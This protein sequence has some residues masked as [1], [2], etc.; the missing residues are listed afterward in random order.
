MVTTTS[1]TRD[2]VSCRHLLDILRPHASFAQGLVVTTLPRGGL[3]I[4]QPLNVSESVL[5]AFSEGLHTEDRL[6]WQAVMTARPVRLSELPAERNGYVDQVLAPLGVKHALALPLSGPVLDGYPGAVHLLRTA[7][8]GEFTAD[9][10]AA[11]TQAVKAFEVDLSQARAGKRGTFGAQHVTQIARP[12]V[13]IVV[14]DGQ[15]RPHTPQDGWSTLDDGLRHNMVE[16]ARRQF[17]HL[18]GTEAHLD[19]ITVSDGHG[20]LWVYNRVVYKKYPALGDGPFTFFCLQPECADWSTVKSADLQADPELSR[21]MP[22]VKF[23]H[24]EYGRGPTLAE[25][26]QQVKLS[27]FHFHRRFTELLGM[28]P[29][30]YMLACQIHQAKVELLAG[31]KELAQIAKECGF[32]H[33]SHFTSRFKQATG[34]TPTRWRRMAMRRGQAANN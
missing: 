25:I 34:L 8:Q 11:L 7:E 31:Q 4:A 9:E 6:T 3:Q 26:S 27:P 33:Q 2:A 12:Q 16:Q 32:A 19:R 10:V 17:Q 20:D 22:A 29:K 15:L 1:A 23:M 13:N 30:Q 21:L 14:L 18:N 5:R 24:T 28:T